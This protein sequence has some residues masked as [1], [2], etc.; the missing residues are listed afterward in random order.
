MA[1]VHAN[2]VDRSVNTVLGQPLEGTLKKTRPVSR[3][4]G[5][6]WTTRKTTGEVTLNFRCRE[7]LEEYPGDLSDHPMTGR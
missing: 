4:R 2:V 1:P 3:L 6:Y 7:K 5:T